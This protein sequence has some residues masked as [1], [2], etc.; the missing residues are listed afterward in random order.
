MSSYSRIKQELSSFRRLVK[1]WLQFGMLARYEN[2]ENKISSDNWRKVR[3][4]SRIK[5]L[6][7]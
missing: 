4:A 6:T 2:K 7:N 3:T 1:C 5:W